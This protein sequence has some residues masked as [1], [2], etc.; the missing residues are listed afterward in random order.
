[1]HLNSNFKDEL[2][3]FIRRTSVELP[4][5]VL[6]SLTRAAR[7]EEPDSAAASALQTILQNVHMSGERTTP[8]CQD[9]GTLIFYV[10]YPTGMST[11]PLRRMIEA[12]VAEATA[13][14]FLRPNA[15]D[16][17]TGKNSG[18]NLGR[19]FPVIHFEEWQQPH[20]R[21]R[22]MLKGG[23]CE[24]VGAQYS[25]P[26][27]R[28]NADRDLAGIKKVI[29][30]AVFQAQGKGCAP[31]ILGVGI[32]G[33]RETSYSISKKQ[34]FRR[35]DD[36]NPN[37]VLAEIEDEVLAK[38][39]QLGIGPMGFGGKTTLLAVKAD[40]AHRLPASFFVSV[41]YMCWADRRRTLIV[42]DGQVEIH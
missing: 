26:N 29:L 27:T 36:R 19:E 28:L 30:D 39:N 5:D 31:G 37:P 16:S 9:T 35:L 6:A 22:L 33:D 20:V 14:S 34:F 32:G 17:L 23:G 12:A 1:M 8:I 18:N 4:E 15:V 42:R 3:T 40:W 11:L 10:D 7:A 38:A 25:L 2:V 41:S 13:K 24:N 21:V